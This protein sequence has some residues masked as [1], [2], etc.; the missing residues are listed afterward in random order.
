[1]ARVH[2][3]PKSCAGD[4]GVIG[5]GLPRANHQSKAPS[6]TEHFVTLGHLRASFAECDAASFK[7]F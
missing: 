5:M 3:M 7:A 6:T 1:M 4:R 2:A